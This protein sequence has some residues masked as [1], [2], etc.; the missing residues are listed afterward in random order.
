[1]SG[2]VKPGRV[3]VNVSPSLIP[4]ICHAYRVRSGVA[5]AA[6]EMT[7]TRMKG[8]NRVRESNLETPFMIHQYKLC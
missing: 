7:A 3:T 1:L 4:T 8:A 5:A 6:T 2:A